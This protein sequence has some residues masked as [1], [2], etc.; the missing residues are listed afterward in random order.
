MR[1]RLFWNVIPVFLNL[2]LFLWNVIPFFEILYSFLNFMT[3]FDFDLFWDKMWKMCV[4]GEF[5]KCFFFKLWCRIFEMW[6]C[7]FHKKT[8]SLIKEWNQ[9]TGIEF[10]TFSSILSQKRSK[11]GHKI[12]E[13]HLKKTVLLFK[14]PASHKKNGITFKKKQYYIS[15]WSTTLI[16]RILSQCLDIGSSIK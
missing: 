9:K 16:L 15:K 8:V 11:F 10:Q 6:C 7:Y 12:K 3:N 13:Y 4:A 2:I 14:K 5:Q 1:R